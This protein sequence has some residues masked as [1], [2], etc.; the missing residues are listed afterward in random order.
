MEVTVKDHRI[1]GIQVTESNISSD[2]FNLA[3]AQRVMDQQSLQVD[4]V[5][6][7]TISTRAFLKAVENALRP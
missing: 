5:S 7:T 3:V 4:T 6:R 1:T 2:D